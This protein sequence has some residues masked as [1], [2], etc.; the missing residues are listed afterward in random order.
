MPLKVEECWLYVATDEDGNE[1]AMAIMGPRGP[2]PLVC[3]N[4]DRLDS[5][6]RLA[7]LIKQETGQDY[8]IRRFVRDPG[9]N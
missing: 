4:P 7:D 9:E 8:E 6:Q 1:G 2:M 5:S 3:A